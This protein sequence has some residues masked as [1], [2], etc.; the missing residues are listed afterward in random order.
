MSK[1]NCF[2]C[3]WGMDTASKSVTVETMITPAPANELVLVEV[4]FDPSLPVGSQFTYALAPNGAPVVVGVDVLP[5]VGGGGGGTNNPEDDGSVIQVLDANDNPIFVEVVWDEATNT[6]T[7]TLPGSSA[8]L[9]PGTDFKPYPPDSSVVT[10]ITDPDCYTWDNAGVQTTFTGYY[11]HTT[12][13]WVALSGTAPTGAEV[14]SPCTSDVTVN[15][16]STASPGCYTWDNAGTE[17]RFTGYY[18]VDTS[19]WVALSGTAPTAGAAVTPCAEAQAD[20]LATPGCYTWDN[21]GTLAQF[22]GYFNVTTGLWV[23]VTGIAPTVAGTLVSLCADAAAPIYELDVESYC[24]DVNQDG[25]FYADGRRIRVIE[26]SATGPT[27]VGA[28]LIEGALGG[29]MLDQNGAPVVVTE[30]QITDDCNCPCPCTTVAPT[31]A[32]PTTTAAPPAPLAQARISSGALNPNNGQVVITSTNTIIAGGSPVAAGEC[33]RILVYTRVPGNTRVLHETITGQ[34]GGTVGSYTSTPAQAGN[35]SVT[36]FIG[37]AQIMMDAA[38]GT[39]FTLNKQNWAAAAGLPVTVELEFD[40]FVGGTA[41]GGGTL[42]DESVNTD[43]TDVICLIKH[44]GADN[45]QI[46]ANLLTG[47][48]SATVTQNSTYSVLQETTLNTGTNGSITSFTGRAIQGGANVDATHF[49]VRNGGTCGGSFRLTDTTDSA[50]IASVTVDGVVTNFAGPVGATP[51][52]APIVNNGNAEIIGSELASGLAATGLF[53]DLLVSNKGDQDPINVDFT[54]C[55]SRVDSWNL[56]QYCSRDTAGAP[57]GNIESFT[58]KRGSQ[59]ADEAV[60]TVV[61]MPQYNF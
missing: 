38:G 45:D 41:C 29:Q 46:D 34:T 27:V 44:S 1:C 28:P 17:A 39:N 42:A 32:A 33:G 26:L 19:L 43:N 50:Y 25:S 51:A 11:N 55:E 6:F 22:I 49:A 13:I 16:V 18:N 12:N 52:E 56:I 4:C 48:L 59:P 8:P 47:S 61:M 54:N 31:T 30:A 58:V 7:Y 40:V 20:Q 23:A 35:T 53:P 60:Y 24:F 36:G 9:N 2:R 14:V 37:N 15:F 21:G 3:S 57:V 5:I 10:V